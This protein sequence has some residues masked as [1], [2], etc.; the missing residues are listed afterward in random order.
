MKSINLGQWQT[1]CHIYP[2]N[3]QYYESRHHGI[4]C[5]VILVIHVFTVL[6]VVISPGGPSTKNNNSPLN[7]SNQ[8]VTSA[9][10]IPH[11]NCDTNLYNGD[12]SPHDLTC[13]VVVC[14]STFHYCKLI[15]WL[16]KK[17]KTDSPQQSWQF[18]HKICRRHN[19]KL[20][21]GNQ[22]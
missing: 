2:F 8:N 16:E 22:K 21:A 18:L 13:T 15:L 10:N 19:L 9:I 7:N 14:H 17:S 5:T 12:Q 11:P 3:E 20:T 6:I 1:K 4:V